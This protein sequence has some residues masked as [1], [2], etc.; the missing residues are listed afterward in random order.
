MGLIN[1]KEDPELILDLLNKNKTL[2]NKQNS[3]EFSF[4][5][6]YKI[7]IYYEKLKELVKNDKN[8]SLHNTNNNLTTK[9]IN[10]QLSR[11]KKWIDMAKTKD[12]LQRTTEKIQTPQFE[13]IISIQ[14]K[15]TN[16]PNSKILIKEKNESPKKP[17]FKTMNSQKL[18]S[19][20]FTINLYDYTDSKIERG[21][22]NFYI[23]NY[24]KF[25]ERVLKGPPDCFRLTSWLI[26]NRI[27][28]ERKREI[29]DF[30][31]IK[32]LNEEIKLSIKKDIQRSFHNNEI[33]ENLR[34]KE[35][36]LYN[37]LK[38][39]SNLDT[40]LGY[41]QGINLIVAFLL[42]ISDFNE[43]ETFFLLISMFSSTF[44]ERGINKN[45]NFSIRGIFSEGFPLL[46]FMNYIY[47]K[48]FTKLLPEL[49][50]K[51]DNFSITYDI[52][53]GKWFQTLFTIVL[54]IDWCKRLFD[55]IF[56]NGIFYLIQF[57]LGFVILLEKNLMKFDDEIEILNFLKELKE[58]PL[59][60][61][62]KYTF[63]LSIKEIINK[64]D[65]IKID[66][67]EYY[68]KYLEKNPSF[69]KEIK[70]NNIMYE[71]LGI[72]NLKNSDNEIIEIN[73]YIN[74]E[75][76]LF[77]NNESKSSNSNELEEKAKLEKELKISDFKLLE[78]NKPNQILS[79]LKIKH[80]ETKVSLNENY[81][82]EIDE[83]VIIGDIDETSILS[84]FPDDQRSVL[85]YSIDSM[86]IFNKDNNCEKS[87]ILQNKN[88][89]IDSPNF[90]SSHKSNFLK[91]KSVNPRLKKNL[92][93]Y[94]KK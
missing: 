87:I 60:N 26:L 67:K 41:C 34:P 63:Q 7:I 31:I 57:G 91:L 6:I 83:K 75:K 62:K 59:K 61:D 93:Q 33:T 27:P 55:C 5:L 16:N 4:K 74:K 65:K 77:E 79:P 11:I 50:K 39:F 54:P 92:D 85:S 44:I 29:Y 32:E 81:D 42:N 52:W 20:E 2:I 30:Y 23:K 25:L 28:L 78:E 19:N 70:S 86:S 90:F 35:K 80:K 36:N 47:D 3:N 18:N 40:N 17:F 46:L 94:N 10:H 84:E 21:I 66:I 51:F 82:D 15:K 14:R 49:K 71:I 38:A 22:K 24:E 69:E 56:V 64:S 72:E 68:N 9:E 8:N 53:I 12:N 73:E 48:E 88:F 89:K 43:T 45:F 76:I 37:V 13:E 1:E 58:Y